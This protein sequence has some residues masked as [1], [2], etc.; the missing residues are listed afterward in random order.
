VRAVR[1]QVPAIEPRF[2]APSAPA[3]APCVAIAKLVLTARRDARLLRALAPYPVR[4]Q[5]QVLCQWLRRGWQ[6]DR[7]AASVA[8]DHP[9][10][11]TVEPTLAELPHRAIRRVRWSDAARGAEAPLRA[12]LSQ[13]KRRERGEEIRRLIARALREASAG[14][15]AFERASARPRRLA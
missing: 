7:G 8:P 5:G 9:T 14:A 6:I 13:L 10:P 11:V 1:R 3:A 15:G 2:A 12:F 4:R